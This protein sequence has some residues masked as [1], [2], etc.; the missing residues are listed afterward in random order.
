MARIITGHNQIMRQRHCVAK[1]LQTTFVTSPVLHL[2]G[3][4]LLMRPILLHLILLLSWFLMTVPLNSV[5]P[6]PATHTLLKLCCPYFYLAFSS[7]LHSDAQQSLSAYFYLAVWFLDTLHGH[8]W[9]FWVS[10]NFQNFQKALKMGEL[11]SN[12]IN[13]IPGC[14]GMCGSCFKHLSQT[15]GTKLCKALW[16][17]N[18]CFSK[19]GKTFFKIPIRS[20]KRDGNKTFHLSQGKH[21]KLQIAKKGLLM[22]GIQH[23]L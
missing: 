17:N 11:H 23:P 6:R 16:Q 9:S 7:V 5:K 22:R 2:S 15:L 14:K 12:N 13:Y 20:Q 21:V 18:F 3:S 10:G 19:K 1:K 8:Y 4:H